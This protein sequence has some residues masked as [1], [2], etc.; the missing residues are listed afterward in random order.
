MMNKK[1][2]VYSGTFDPFTTGHLNLVERAVMLCDELIIAVS[3]HQKKKTVFSL[4]ER[5]QMILLAIP[6]C[7]NIKVIEFEGL[8][9]D[10]C[11]ENQANA[12]V[13]GVRNQIDLDYEKQMSTINSQLNKGIETVFLLAK[14]E[15]IHI[16]SSNVKELAMYSD[17]FLGMIPD[18]NIDF[19]RRKLKKENKS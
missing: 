11:R 15:L 19:V 7:D 8:I 4:E 13:R 1:I 10:F 9:A 17:E 16:S 2:W 5:I 12:I 14:E 3:N 18:C 6:H